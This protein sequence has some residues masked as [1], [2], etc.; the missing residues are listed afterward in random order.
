LNVKIARWK[1]GYRQRHLP[2]TC[3]ARYEQSAWNRWIVDWLGHKRRLYL[4]S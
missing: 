2:I 4:I 1:P 3:R